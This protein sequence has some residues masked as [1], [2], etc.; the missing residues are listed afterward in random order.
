MFRGTKPH[1]NFYLQRFQLRSRWNVDFLDFVSLLWH[2]SRLAAH[3]ER[4]GQQVQAVATVG[5]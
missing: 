4:R 1:E 2:P 3:N 5:V